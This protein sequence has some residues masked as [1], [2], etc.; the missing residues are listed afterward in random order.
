[1][2]TPCW[3]QRTSTTR[4]AT[5]RAPRAIDARS[6]ARSKSR[7]LAMASARSESS[8]PLGRLTV[9]SRG[10]VSAVKRAV[11]ATTSGRSAEARASATSSSA[12]AVRPPPHGFS[13]G[14]LWS[15]STTLAPADASW[16]AAH[17]PAGPPPTIAMSGVMRTP[18]HEV[19]VR[20]P[21]GYGAMMARGRGFHPG[22]FL[23]YSRACLIRW[24]SRCLPIHQPPSVPRAR[25][26]A[27]GV[28]ARDLSIIARDHAAEGVM[29]REVGATPG[30]EIED[31]WAVARL[32]ELG[33]HI[34]AAIAIVMPGIGPIISAGPLGCRTR[35]SRGSCRR[36][37]GRRVAGG[38]AGR[39][40][41]RGVGTQHR[42]RRDSPGS[43]RPR[44]ESRRAD[45]AARG[46]PRQR[47]D[48]NDLGR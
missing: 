16:C 26:R 30:V 25:L 12:R 2:V 14:W 22:C 23:N 7:R 45:P 15:N 47:G 44:R 20:P 40:P 39:H 11:L 46:A 41:G 37:A 6:K 1:M 48:F 18:H 13:L 43:A 34:L 19:S 9:A 33:G 3:S 5:W 24:C 32:G 8:G 29:A 36:K 31:S 35:R 10:V 4:S 21:A 38:R 42:S 17:A 27:R 28:Q